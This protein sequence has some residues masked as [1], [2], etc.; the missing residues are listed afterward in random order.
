MPRF[1]I[2]DTPVTK[3]SEF[4]T[5][6]QAA[7]F[8]GVSQN[9]LRNWGRDGRIKE[10]RHPVNHYRLYDT[11][12]LSQLLHQADQPREATVSNRRTAK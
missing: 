1:L 4:M 12:E 6:K 9:T 11:E 2:G 7:E 8:L 3:L 10:R 5:I